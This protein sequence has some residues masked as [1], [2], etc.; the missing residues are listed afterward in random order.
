MKPFRTELSPIPSALSLRHSDSILAMGSC[1]AAHI[2]Q[3]LSDLKFPVCL[4]PFGII[5]H[6]LALANN[7]RRIV[8]KIPYR[9]EDLLFHEDCWHSLDHHS[10]FSHPDP[11]TV[12]ENINRSLA[13][14]AQALSSESTLFLSLGSA[15]GFQHLQKEQIVA[16]CHKIPAVAFERFRSTPEEVVAA[17]LEALDLLF[18]HYPS[19]K[20]VITVSPV[21]H[22]RDGLVE[23]QRSKAVL[24]LAAEQLV[25]AREQIHYFPAYELLLDDLRDYRF[26]KEDLLHPNAQAIDYIWSFFGQTYFSE[27]TLAL[28]KRIDKLLHAARHRPFHPGLVAHQRFLR[29]QLMQLTKLAQEYPHL[30]FQAERETFERDLLI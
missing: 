25:E 18:S 28:N 21:R 11:N 4:N 12:L 16:N 26:Y 8:Q 27:T 30:D 2:G 14:A 6:P 9:S 22:L 17:L 5:Y 7:L 15:Y 20:C 13:Q 19:I 10:Q 24:L 3:R 23:N 29:Q 1:F